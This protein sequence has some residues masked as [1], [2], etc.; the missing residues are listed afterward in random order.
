MKK[1][2]KCLLMS[3][4]WTTAKTILNFVLYVMNSYLMLYFS[5]SRFYIFSWSKKTRKE[6]KLCIVDQ[7]PSWNRRQLFHPKQSFFNIA[8]SPKTRL[9][10]KSAFFL[11]VLYNRTVYLFLLNCLRTIAFFRFCFFKFWLFLNARGT[12]R[13]QVLFSFYWKN[14]HVQKHWVIYKSQK[15]LSSWMYDDIFVRCQL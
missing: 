2:F 11:T 9:H 1:S 12:L 7:D 15:K 4:L 14:F 6:E 13:T 8:L 10:S 3:L 5:S